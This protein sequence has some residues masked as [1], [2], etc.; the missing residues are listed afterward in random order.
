MQNSNETKY[1]MWQIRVW[2]NE[3]HLLIENTLENENYDHEVARV[4]Q[5]LEI[6][7]ELMQSLNLTGAIHVCRACAELN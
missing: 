4:R 5:L 2:N 7:A 1:A 6:H 3:F